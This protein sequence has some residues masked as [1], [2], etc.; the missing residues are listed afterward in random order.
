[1]T[2]LSSL[3]RG[4]FARVAIAMLGLGYRWLLAV[5][6][7]LPDTFVSLLLYRVFKPRLTDCVR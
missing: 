2:T 1:M 4:V 7:L 3:E 5:C 6:L